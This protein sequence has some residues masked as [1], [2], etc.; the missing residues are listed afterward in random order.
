MKNRLLKVKQPND[1][2]NPSVGRLVGRS[3]LYDVCLSYIN[4][5][6]FHLVSWQIKDPGD[7]FRN[8]IEIKLKDTDVVD[9]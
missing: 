4:I 6:L 7:A 3:V 5:Y 1:P 9:T 2:D 8:T